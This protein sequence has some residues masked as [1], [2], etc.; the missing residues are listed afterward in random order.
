[1]DNLEADELLAIIAELENEALSSHRNS[2]RTPSDNSLPN[3]CGPTTLIFQELATKAAVQIAP[4]DWLLRL[5]KIHGVDPTSSEEYLAKSAFYCDGKWDLPLE[6]ECDPEVLE[7]RFMD[8]FNEVLHHFGLR[9]CRRALATKPQRSDLG[10]YLFDD[11]FQAYHSKRPDLLILGCD[12]V[13]FP[14]TD[15]LTY[16]RRMSMDEDGLRSLYKACLSVGKVDPSPNPDYIVS[17]IATC[18]RYDE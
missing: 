7:R 18:A 9:D 11:G 14:E 4:Q 6:A 12:P 17:K 10:D 16:D 15:F 2:V 13:Y 8:I 3:V 1:M 5:M